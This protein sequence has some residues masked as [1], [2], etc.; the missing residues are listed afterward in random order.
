MTLDELYKQK[1]ELITKS[2]LISIQLKSIN[3]KIV[4]VINSRGRESAP[5]IKPN[6]GK[7]PKKGSR[8]S[9]LTKDDT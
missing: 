2:E 6:N 9:T 4:E 7:V 1:G 8:I 5:I 3:E